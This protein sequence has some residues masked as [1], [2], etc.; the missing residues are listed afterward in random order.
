MQP[1]VVATS[2]PIAIARAWMRRS[3]FAISR[4][5]STFATSPAALLNARLTTGVAAPRIQIALDVVTEEE[6]AAL[7]AQADSWFAGK[8]YEPGHF[9]GVASQYREIQKPP[10]RFSRANRAII[11]RLALATLPAG[12]PLMPIHLLDLHAEGAIGRHVDH[13][14]YSGAYIVGLSLLS[15]AVMELHHEHSTSSIEMLLPRR[16]AY[17]LTAEARYQ[18]AHVVPKEPSFRGREIQKTRR[19]SILLRDHAAAEAGMPAS[20]AT[21]DGGTADSPPTSMGVG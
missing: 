11:D 10:R 9:D 3:T 5:C 6:E 15:E 8:P 12:V 7:V 20:P 13:T 16:S 17:V 1:R 4:R 21:P 19:L 2:A 18:W 14:E